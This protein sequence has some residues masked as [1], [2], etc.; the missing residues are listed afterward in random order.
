M[1]TRT[2][3]IA[4]AILAGFGASAAPGQV[5]HVRPR[6]TDLPPPR[7]RP[8]PKNNRALIRDTTYRRDDAVGEARAA[9]RR[10]EITARQQRKLRRIGHRLLAPRFYGLDVLADLPQG[11]A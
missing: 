1:T 2:A 3:A 6:P 7:R 4:L 10:G 11:K 9:R 8:R 5:V